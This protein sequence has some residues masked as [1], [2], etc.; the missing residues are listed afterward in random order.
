VARGVSRGD[1]EARRR[2]PL[3][4]VG[5]VVRLVLDGEL[6]LRVVGDVVLVQASGELAGDLLKRAVERV[7]ID[8]LAGLEGDFREGV[9]HATSSDG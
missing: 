7:G 2:G 4:L 3:D 9:W 5:V 1:V 6:R 8:D